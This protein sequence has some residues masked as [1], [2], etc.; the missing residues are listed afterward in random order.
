MLPSITKTGRMFAL[1]GINVFVS[2]KYFIVKSLIFYRH[3]KYTLFYIKFQMDATAKREFSLKTQTILL[4][5]FG[6]FVSGNKGTE[7]V[8]Y[9]NALR[10]SMIPKGEF[11]LM[12][13]C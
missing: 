1:K 13:I 8:V 12:Q 2:E 5:M 3:L 9:L 6:D 7:R 10:K 11:S 4:S